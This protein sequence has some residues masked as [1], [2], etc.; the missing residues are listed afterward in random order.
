MIDI[1]HPSGEVEARQA[2]TFDQIRELVGGHVQMVPV[3]EGSQLLHVCMNE[4]PLPSLR[5]N[6]RA[7][8]RFR[9]SINIGPDGA[10][11]VWVVLSGKDLLK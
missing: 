10:L 3:K 7:T 4:D 8:M 6:S 9:N 5:F 11:G 1:L 2:L